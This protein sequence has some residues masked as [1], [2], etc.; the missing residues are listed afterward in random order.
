[1]S[2]SQLSLLRKA[3]TAGVNRQVDIASTVPSQ[4]IQTLL[5]SQIKTTPQDLAL[6]DWLLQLQPFGTSFLFRVMVKLTPLCWALVVSGAAGFEHGGHFRRT[7]E[8]TMKAEGTFVQCFRFCF[9]NFDVN[10][11]L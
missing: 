6:L 1:M 2:P 8:M 3:S 5:P 9:T 11:N 4:I 10:F 7:N